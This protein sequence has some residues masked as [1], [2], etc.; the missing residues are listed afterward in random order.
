MSLP[1]GPR[2]QG[3]RPSLR[4]LLALW[5]TR[6][7][8]C[9]PTKNINVSKTEGCETTAPGESSPINDAF[10]IVLT[11]LSKGRTFDRHVLLSPILLRRPTLTPVHPIVFFVRETSEGLDRRSLGTNE[12][13]GH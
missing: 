9:G 10:G 8:T 11:L 5:L 1:G 4:L 13:S 12:P 7:K 3:S 6:G 2:T